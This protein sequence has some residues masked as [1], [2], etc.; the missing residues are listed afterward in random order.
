[1][2]QKRLDYGFSGYQVP[3]IPRAA[4][5]S[6]KRRPIREKAV[7]VDNQ[8]CAFDLLATV[9]GKLLEGESSQNLP[10]EKDQLGD[11][12]DVVMQDQDEGTL[13]LK[14]ELCDKGDNEVAS[15]NLEL[16]LQVQDQGCN[17]KE[18]SVPQNDASPAPASVITSSHCPEKDEYLVKMDTNDDKS[19]FCSLSRSTEGFAPGHTDSCVPNVNESVEDHDGKGEVLSGNGLDMHCSEDPEFFDGNSPAV[20]SSDCSIKL[21]LGVDHY[22]CGS[23]SPRRDNNVKVVTRD[24]DENSS[25]CTQPSTMKPARLPARIGDRRI[26]KLLASKHWRLASKVKDG[27]HSDTGL[28]CIYRSRRTGYKRPRSQRIYPFKKRKFYHYSSL[29]NSDVDDGCKGNGSS[30]CDAGQSTSFASRES[31]VKLRIKSFRVPEL[32]IEMPETATVG[33]LKRTVMEAVTALLGGGLRV[34][35]RLQGK[36]IRDDNRTLVQ[37][38]ICHDDK[39]ESLGFTL[40]P[41]PSHIGTP[42]SSEDN[43]LL[44]STDVP[45]P[46][47]RCPTLS[48]NNQGASHDHPVRNL[49][50]FVES[51]HDSAPSP[52]EI[53][54]EKGSVDSRALVALP[55]GS[56]QALAVVPSHQKS[57][58]SEMAQRRIRRPFSVTEVESLVQAVEKLGTGRWRDVK[59]RAFDN[60]KHRT[61]VDLKDK[62]KTLVHTARIS[63]QQRR[64]EPVPQELLDRVL[65]AH[66][67]WSQQQAKQQL[68][69][70][71][72]DA[73]LLL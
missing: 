73:C 58:R 68:K 30:S 34:G 29:L 63:P 31:H 50:N 41:N 1:M 64:G 57:K 7:A 17:V 39:V 19:D 20:A 42:V 46:V 72:S 5:S 67:Y 55:E 16:G 62:W 14:D 71:P 11:V 45:Q 24:D 53:T 15:L 35:V 21:S 48:V 27:D 60:V 12:Q 66:S 13:C 49:G 28:R 37:S 70:Q 56:P 33:S 10:I 9:A 65:T 26:R 23:L 6:R 38:G 59:L 32:F 51:D 69:Q 2:L 40:E 54:A 8:L 25:E 43:S 3:F 22:P 44:L 61:Y 18:I 4:R 47:S 52:A 36:K